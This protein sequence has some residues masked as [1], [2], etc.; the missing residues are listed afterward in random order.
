MPSG[1]IFNTSPSAKVRNDVPSVRTSN[2]QTGR[3]G[4]AAAY[5]QAGTPIG[6]LLVLTYAN[7]FFLGSNPHGP[8]PNVRILTA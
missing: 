7:S 4:E 1:R 8:R 2:F 3:G 6:L 5:V